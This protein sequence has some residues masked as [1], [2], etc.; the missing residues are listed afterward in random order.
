MKDS[1]SS[2]EYLTCKENFESDKYPEAANS[3]PYLHLKGEKVT[4]SSLHS[5]GSL[6]SA[7]Q[8]SR[9]Q[10]FHGRF[11]LQTQ[12]SLRIDNVR[13]RSMS[14]VRTISGSD[15]RAS[16]EKIFHTFLLKG[17]EREINLPLNI[18]SR[19][20]KSIQKESCHDPEVFEAAKVYTFEKIERG[21]FLDFLRYKA[22]GNL[23]QSSL[24]FRLI[25]GLLAVFGGFW[26]GFLCILLDTP[27]QR[28]YWVSIFS[29]S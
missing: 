1:S 22:L 2:S 24:V 13:T 27:I 29:P 10:L 11:D 16:A 20:T 26:A 8:G 6:Q 7:P 19:I 5:L 18:I 14:D 21:A 12:S 23:V 17:S 15:I 28:R 9:D 3:N 25:I 4:S